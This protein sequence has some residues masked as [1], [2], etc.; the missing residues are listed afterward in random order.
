MQ[1]HLIES[2]YREAMVLADA[3]RACFDAEAPDGAPAV[4]PMTRLVLSCESLKVTARL[5]QV[6]AWLLTR[7]AV[8]RG[9]MRA[10]AVRDAG[11][12]PGPAPRTDAS[13]LLAMPAPARAVVNASIDLYRRVERIEQAHDAPPAAS[14]ARAMFERLATAL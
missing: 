3:A 12:M 9:E 8:Q 10:D 13:A 4:D 5:M 11:R 7:R 1:R 2:L 14:P 6:T